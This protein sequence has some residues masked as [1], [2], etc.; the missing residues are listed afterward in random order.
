M[1]CGPCSNMGYTG[2]RSCGNCSGTG[3]TGGVMSG[4]SKCG[5]CNG[6]GQ[7]CTQCGA[8]NGG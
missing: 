1:A 8:P 2:S 7:L 3:K 5:Q 4:Q 6:T